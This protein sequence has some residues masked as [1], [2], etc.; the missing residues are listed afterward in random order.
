[1]EL[2]VFFTKIFAELRLKGFVSPKLIEV[3]SMA[4]FPDPTFQF[5]PFASGAFQFHTSMIPKIPQPISIT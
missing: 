4:I 1:M 5:K 2:P 3:R